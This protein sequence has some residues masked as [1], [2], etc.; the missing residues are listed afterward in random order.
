M[1]YHHQSG[2]PKQSWQIEYWRGDDRFRASLHLH[3]NW[4]GRVIGCACFCRVA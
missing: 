2:Y 3:W 4:F 1:S